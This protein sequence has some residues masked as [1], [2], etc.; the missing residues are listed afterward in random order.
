[1][2]RRSGRSGELAHRRGEVKFFCER[3]TV[4]QHAPVYRC[5]ITAASQ[6]EAAVQDRAQPF[7]IAQADRFCVEREIELK[8]WAICDRSASRNIAASHLSGKV[9]NSHLIVSKVERPICVGKPE[10]GGYRGQRNIL[11]A[12]LASNTGM[13]R[14]SGAAHV[15]VH[16]SGTLQIRA[17]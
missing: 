12:D 2:A 13:L 8:L 14:A 17:E 6:S 4:D 9:A 1:A 15:D 16:D 11:Q 7:R 5:G 3:S 10:R